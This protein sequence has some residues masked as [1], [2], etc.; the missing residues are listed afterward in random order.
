V[1]VISQARSNQNVRLH[2]RDGCDRSIPT[3]LC[4]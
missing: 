2:Q 4:R 3:L 1:Q